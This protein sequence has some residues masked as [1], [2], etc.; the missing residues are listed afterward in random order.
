MGWSRCSGEGGCSGA[1]SGPPD[2]A[3]GCVSGQTI[4]L[5]HEARGW[6]EVLGVGRKGRIG[7]ELG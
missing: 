2:L 5:A 6:L 7:G 4:S 3:T 1:R